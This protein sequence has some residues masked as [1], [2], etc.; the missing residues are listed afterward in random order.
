MNYCVSGHH[1]V[2]CS[3]LCCQKNCWVQ[4]ISSNFVSV[5]QWSLCTILFMVSMNTKT[6]FVQS[7][8]SRQI[9]VRYAE[10]LE[11]MLKSTLFS[12]NLVVSCTICGI[13]L[14]EV[15]WRA[16]YTEEWLR[17][18]CLLLPKFLFLISHFA[19]IYKEHISS[20]GK[21][22]KTKNSPQKDTRKGTIFKR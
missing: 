12:V 14:S 6:L 18:W 11:Q 22:C 19:V 5:Y 16:V 13:L 2:S 1:T 10:R 20:I 17:F 7:I 9:M 21:L 3:F 4:C 8:D 15:Y